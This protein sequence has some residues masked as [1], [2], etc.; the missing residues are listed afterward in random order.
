MK[1]KR[2]IT[3]FLLSLGL[4]SVAALHAPD[5]QAADSA[6][7]CVRMRETIEGAGLTLSVDNNCDRRLA[8]SVTWTVQCESATG[9]ATKRVKE[10]A[11]LVVGSSASKD[12]YASAKTCGDNW[13]IEEVSWDCSPLK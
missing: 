1:Q 8:C 2:A 9:K 5:A 11:Q 3:A 6:N 10:G 12:A 4:L 7:D 13:K